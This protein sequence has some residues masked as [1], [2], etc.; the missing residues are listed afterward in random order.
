MGRPRL[1]TEITGF[2]RCIL[3]MLLYIDCQGCLEVEREA[4]LHIK[5]S[6][7]SPIASA[8]SILEL[9]RKRMLRVECDPT[10]IHIHSIFFH[11]WREQGREVEP[12]YPNATL[13]AQFE[14]LKQLP[15]PRESYRRIRFTSCIQ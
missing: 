11:Y 13:F 5:D 10:R 1:L 6:M 12:W 3:V 7:T 8:F 14:E 15:T 4:L 9:V 2:Y